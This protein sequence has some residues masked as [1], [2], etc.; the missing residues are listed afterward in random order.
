MMMSGTYNI[1][2]QLKFRATQVRFILCA[3]SDAYVIVKGGP[4]ASDVA[5]AQAGK[6]NK[7]LTFKNCASCTHCISKINNTQL[8]DAENLDFLMLVYKLTEYM[9]IIQKHV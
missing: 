6:L 7:G 2:S 4:E 3:Y 1:N 5:T 9:I 8:D